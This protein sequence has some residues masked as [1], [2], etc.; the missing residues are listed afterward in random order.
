VNWKP[1]Y[2]YY[3]L[4]FGITWGVGGL[5]L[6]AGAYRPAFA[7]STAN[8]LY[9]V[10]ACGPTIAGLIMVGRR[11]GRAG[12][13]RLLS[14]AVPTRAGLP[15]YFGVIVGFPAVAL[16]AGRLEA[17]D[18]LAN[19]PRWDRLLTLLPLTLVT[20]P[21]PLGEEFGWR[22][23]ALPFLLRRRP[24]LAAALI[25]GAVWAVWHLPAFFIPTLSQSRLWFP[26]FLVNSVALSVIMT[27]LYLRT[28]GDLLLMILVHLMAN[29]SAG[30]LGV[31]FNAEVG[32]EVACAALIVA[33]GGLRSG[34]RPGNGAS[35]TDQAAAGMTPDPATEQHP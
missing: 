6:L 12:L 17:P 10:A 19:L 35:L 20:D 26:L 32:G 7:L 2:R 24:P 29:Y 13:K 8:P 11:E 31:P 15:W 1:L 5:G 9:Y 25:L 34:V 30:V 3:G 23:F 14:G 22:G 18:I 27:W 28:G 16:A 33:A 21:G 4:A